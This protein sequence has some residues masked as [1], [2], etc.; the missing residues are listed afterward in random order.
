MD[1]DRFAQESSWV[2]LVMAGG[3][4]IQSIEDKNVVVKIRV[5]IKSFGILITLIA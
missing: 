4:F 5:H 2:A 3:A 1:C